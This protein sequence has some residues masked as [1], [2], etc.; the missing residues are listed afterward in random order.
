M[1]KR[2]MQQQILKDTRGS[3]NSHTPRDADTAVTP[4]VSHTPNICTQKKP[5]AALRGIKRVMGDRKTEKRLK[6]K[7]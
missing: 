6:N 7:M 5:N 3:H 2:N 4:T 1:D